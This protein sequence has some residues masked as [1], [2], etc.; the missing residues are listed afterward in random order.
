MNKNKTNPIE[1]TTVSSNPSS[2]YFLRN[3][4][5][6]KTNHFNFF[7]F[8]DKF[9]KLLMR[10]GKKIKAAKLFFDMLLFLK[11]KIQKDTDKKISLVKQF[12]HNLSVLHFL[13][14][15]VE[16]VTPSLEVRKVRVS[17]TTYLVPAILSKKRQQTTAIRWIIESAKK[18]QNKSNLSFSECLADEIFDAYK[19][20][21][22]ARQKRDELH[23]LAEANRAY[24]RYRW[25]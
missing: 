7:L 2:D 25:W 10:D 18:K 9:I 1:N 4:K 8:T 21:G 13:S 6:N 17:G 20:Q 15:A 14:K 5:K 19:K 12:M 23:R 24:I 22:Q 16:N 3:K 11:K